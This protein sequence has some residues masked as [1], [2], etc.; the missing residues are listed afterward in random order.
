M[1]YS[2]PAHP[3]WGWLQ[4][5]LANNMGHLLGYFSGVLISIAVHVL[6]VGALLINW[7]PSS[8]KVMIQPQYIEAKLV[9]LSPKIKPAVKTP[10]A[11]LPIKPRVDPK[12][13]KREAD[14]RRAAEKIKAAA[15]RKKQEQALRAKELEE[16]RLAEL[17]RKRIESEFADTLNQAE[18]QINAL[19]DDRVANS[20][21]QLIQQR[22]SENW[23]RPPSA[24]REMET[25]IR[26]SLG[27]SFRVT[28][29]TL[30]ESSGD[31]AFDR[32]VEQAAWKAEQFIELEGMEDRLFQSRFRE[33]DVAFSPQ[34]KRL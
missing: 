24:R 33:V 22:L 1:S 11:K 15:L 27:F 31:A 20:Y 34:D 7:Q 23:S 25:M 14:K 4:S 5:L 6:V 28:G 18:A 8:E 17:E 19:E 29:V 26:I 13:K 16:Q 2:W 12:K 9:E 10:S 21:R 32:S 30:L 3:L